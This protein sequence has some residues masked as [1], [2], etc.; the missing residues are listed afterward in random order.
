ME[1][2]EVIAARHSVRKFA[3]KKVPREILEEMVAEAGLAPSS[4]NSRSS[5][6]IIVE[7]PELIK[8]MSL[9]RDHG[10]AFL[11]GAPAAIVVLGDTDKA[12]MWVDNASISTTYLMLSAVD[13]GLGSCWVHVNGR[14][15]V[16]ADPSLGTAEDY[17]LPLLAGLPVLGGE[18]VSRGSSPASGTAAPAGSPLAGSPSPVGSSLSGIASLPGGEPSLFAPGSPLRP[19]CV[20]ALGYEAL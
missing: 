15:R 8:A 18:P 5:R 7:D 3:D 19:L 4:R 16:S 11:A 10:A 2:K 9:M 17:L 1:F 6:F 20:L 14:P 12:D 13:R